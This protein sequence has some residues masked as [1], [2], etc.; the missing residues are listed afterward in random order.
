[1][2]FIYST[3]GNKYQRKT[4]KDSVVLILLSHLLSILSTDFTSER[5]YFVLVNGTRSKCSAI[6]LNAKPSELEIYN[7]FYSINGLR[8]ACRP[9]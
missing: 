6:I 9:E 3:T 4:F 8:I 2:L 1:M 7:Q 5:I